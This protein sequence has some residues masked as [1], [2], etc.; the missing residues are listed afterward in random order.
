MS[1]PLLEVRNLSVS[2]R[3]GS[4][5]LRAVC[6][7]SFR[8]GSGETLALVGESGCGKSS[9]ALAI[10]GLTDPVNDHVPG[11]ILFE[12]EPLPAPRTSQW[13]ELAG[14]RLAMVFQDA[15]ASLNPVLTVESHLVEA[16]K[17]HQR[18]TRRAALTRARELLERVGIPDPQLYGRRYPFEL[19][20]GMCQRVAI[21]L[22]ICHGPSLLLADEPTSALDPTIQLQIIG[23]LQ[24]L[25]RSGDLSLLLISHDLALVREIADRVAVMYHGL[26]VEEGVVDEI[27]REPAHPYTRALLE[28]S[29]RLEHHRELNPLVPVRG[30]PPRPGEVM[31]GCPFEP[32]CPLAKLECQARIPQAVER[33]TTHWVRCPVT[34]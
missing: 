23:L 24:H 1:Q 20:G 26:W 28:S 19:S 5:R 9:L 16:L 14:R 15:Q 21:A 32:R 4:G 30:F 7:V 18:L 25:Q 11:E 29:P 22:G 17:A 10:M 12:G 13:R 33:T 34:G 27:F 31:D 8:L 2:Y 3:A 6:D